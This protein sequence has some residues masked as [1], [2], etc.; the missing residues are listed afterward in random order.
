VKRRPSSTPRS[1]KFPDERDEVK[2]AC[3]ISKAFDAEPRLRALRWNG[4]MD[5]S[6]GAKLPPRKSPQPLFRTRF[7][8]TT[9]AHISL[10]A[11]FDACVNIVCHFA[12]RARNNT[13]DK[14][15]GR[16]AT[17]RRKRN[18]IIIAIVESFD[19]VEISLISHRMFRGGPHS[20]FMRISL[21]HVVTQKGIENVNFLRAH[22]T[23]CAV[24]NVRSVVD[25]A[26]TTPLP[27]AR[28]R[29]HRTRVRLLSNNSSS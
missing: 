21:L 2:P 1:R 14:K 24:I 17:S 8:V 23:I 13:T 26:Q 19:N 12:G 20:Q 28:R 4:G 16:S 25:G 29:F 27:R 3:D 22:G 10:L 11:I 18:Y 7:P 15:G 6:L 9:F 5:F